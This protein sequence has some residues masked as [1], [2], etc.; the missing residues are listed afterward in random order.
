MET[1]K[2]SLPESW[3]QVVKQYDGQLFKFETIA[4]KDEILFAIGDGTIERPLTPIDSTQD[5]PELNFPWKEKFWNIY[6]TGVF[7]PNDMC[8]RL[9]GADYSDALDRLMNE[10]EMKMMTN[11]ERPN[12]IKLNFIYLTSIAECWHRIKTIEINEKE[13]NCICIDNGEYEWIPRDDIYVCKPEF[14]TVAPQSFKLALFG[15]EEFEN[16]PTSALAQQ[17][18]YEPFVYKSLVA[19]IMMNQEFF[20]MNKTKPIKTILYDTST[21]EDVNLNQKLMN[22]LLKTVTA[23]TLNQKESNQI[24][25]THIGEDSIFGQLVKSSAYIQQLINNV[26]KEEITQHRGLH[27]DYS[28]QQGRK[29]IYLVFDSKLKNWFRARYEKTIEANLHSMYMIDHGYSSKFNTIDV[30]RLDKVS[31]VLSL[32]PPQAIRMTLSNVAYNGDVK[33]RLLGMLPPGRRQA[34]VS[35]FIIYL[36]YLK[37]FFFKN[38]FFF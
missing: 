5:I 3:D 28:T 6:I 9:I 17:T 33:K 30:Y 12:E 4:F 29:K 13:V 19:E 1:Y 16:N 21:E 32:Y 2:L 7:S 35:F 24:I 22:T 27:E 37:I 31:Y 20:E 10:I 38:I 36:I 26:S 15:L 8:A 14:L 18:L 23:P 34:F 11:K 25:V